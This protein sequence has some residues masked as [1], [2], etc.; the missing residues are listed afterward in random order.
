MFIF[1]G[2]QAFSCNQL[3]KVLNL[4][5]YH[6]CLKVGMSKC[7]LM[8]LFL[9][10]SELPWGWTDIFIQ[11]AF[12]T[13]AVIISN[14][15]TEL[16]CSLWHFSWGRGR[17]SCCCEKLAAL[18]LLP[19]ETATSVLCCPVQVLTLASNERVALTPS[20]KLLFEIHHLRTA[21]PATVSRAGILY[22]NPQDL[23]WNP[24]VWLF[25]FLLW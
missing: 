18:P 17:T 24:W 22:V 25:F 12:L 6:S 5:N 4:D 15:G 8:S 14:L 20:M 19:N 11:T 7:M 3:L 1:Y 16:I 9:V 10:V 13:R 2:I 21:T 23:G